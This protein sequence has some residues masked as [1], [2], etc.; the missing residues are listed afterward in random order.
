VEDAE[1]GEEQ[2]EQRCDAGEAYAIEVRDVYGGDGA[3]ATKRCGGDEE[4]GDG[5]EHLHAELAVP[6]EG[7]DQLGWEAFGVRDLCEEQAHVD[8][9]HQDEEDGEAAEEVDA[10]EAG[11]MGWCRW[12]CGDHGFIV[13]DEGADFVGEGCSWGPIEQTTAKANTGIL[14]CVQDDDFLR[15]LF[16][17]DLLAHLFYDDRLRCLF[18]CD[19]DGFGEGVA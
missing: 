7:R 13:R 11:P 16:C 5:E 8:V 4:A 19:G 10:V 12:L 9:V 3:P 14:H 17:D 18:C 6:D 1:D 2:Q 15:Y